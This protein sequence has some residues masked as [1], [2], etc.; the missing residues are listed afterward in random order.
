VFWMCC[1]RILALLNDLVSMLLKRLTYF[2]SDVVHF[3]AEKD[4]M[5]DPIFARLNSAQPVSS[6]SAQMWSS[7]RGP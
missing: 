4:K 6:S 7:W 1:G 2:G 5:V 3:S